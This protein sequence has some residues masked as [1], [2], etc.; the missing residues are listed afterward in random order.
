MLVSVT[1]WV[2]FFAPFP[3]FVLVVEA[4]IAMALNEYVT[5]A[6]KKGIR[7]NRPVMLTLG[8]AAPVLELASATPLYFTAI[9]TVLFF[10]HLPKDDFQHAFQGMATGLF[11]LIWIAW[12]FSYLPAMRTLPAG[13]QWVFY[14]IWVA[15]TG[16]A[17]AYFAGKRW[18]RRKFIQ[19]VSPNKTWEGALAQMVVSVLASLMSGFYVPVSWIHLTVLGLLLGVLAQVGDLVESVA[20]RNLEA[21]DSGV[22]PGLGGILDVLDSLLLAI[23]FVYFYAA[24]P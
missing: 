14:T 11:G 12:L 8:L 7:L 19:H 9:L 13:A 20:K 4:F 2:I 16:D 22:L 5:M 1:S 15:K 23:P 18:G 3:L 24:T 10:A 21:K 6:Q 17:A